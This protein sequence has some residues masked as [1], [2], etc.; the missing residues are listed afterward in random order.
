MARALTI[1][2]HPHHVSFEA[3]G[4]RI[5]VSANDE[6]VV[7]RLPWLPPAQARPSDVA[8][9]DH[10]IDI[11][12]R[13]GL[14]FNAKYDVHPDPADGQELDEDI[15]VAGDADLE[16][17]C[18]MVE[19]HVHGCIAL[20]A[21]KH[22]FIRGGAVQHRGRAIVLPAEGLAG[23]STLV[24]AL[25]RAGAT[26]YSEEYAVFDEQGRLH[27]YT[28]TSSVPA[29]A[30]NGSQSVDHAGEP[31]PREAAAVVFTSY[32]PEAEWRP[33]Q[34]TR[35]ESMLALLAHAVSGEESPK[36]TMSAVARILDGD[37]VVMRSER[38]EA[39]ALAPLLLAELGGAH[40]GAA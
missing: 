32:R 31:E 6:R 4:V 23:T 3:F 38:D 40:S 17:V 25:T 34:M 30:A 24:S 18:A 13:D 9:V 20:N 11:T 14:R 7:A 37:P 1:L 2:P 8:G 28:K 27:A 5:G 19:A 39:D 36:E 12:T 26:P 22:V 33:Q 15:W 16:L 29:A 10:H 21:P 35:G